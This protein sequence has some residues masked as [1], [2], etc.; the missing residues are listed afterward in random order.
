MHLTCNACCS[1]IPKYNIKERLIIEEKIHFSFLNSSKT[2]LQLF[3]LI[4]KWVVLSYTI[5]WTLICFLYLIIFSL[6]E[7]NSL[8]GCL[9]T[10][11]LKWIVW[12][13]M[14]EA[15]C[16]V[17]MKVTIIHVNIVWYFKHFI[18][19]YWIYK[20]WRKHNKK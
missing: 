13:W 3:I 9:K 17:W 7:G 14:D 15:E 11:R 1:Y 2:N 18:H 16:K 20:N 12:N 19:V 4:L 6:I 8:E 5:H 10:T